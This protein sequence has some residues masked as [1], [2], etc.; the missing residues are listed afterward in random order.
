MEKKKKTYSISFE[1][2]AFDRHADAKRISTNVKNYSREIKNMNGH[3]DKLDRFDDF[4]SLKIPAEQFEKFDG[5]YGIARTDEHRGRDV[6]FA[7]QTRAALEFLRDKRGFGLL[8]DVVGSGKTY[9]AGLVVSELAARNKVRSILFI[10]PSQAI[11]DW[12][13]VM[14]MQFGFGKGSLYH[15]EDK[16]DKDGNVTQIGVPNR[17]NLMI[18][19]LDGYL[20]PRVPVIITYEQFVEWGSDC[21]D[22]LFDVIVV[23][24]AHHLCAE[25]G[26]YSRAMKSLSMLV[27]LK[28]KAKRS[29]CLLLSATPHS[30]NLKKMFR[31]WYFIRCTGGDPDDFDEKDDRDRTDYYRTEKQYYEDIVCKKAATVMDFVMIAK[32]E[33]VE[34]SLHW[35]AFEKYLRTAPPEEGKPPLFD[36]YANGTLAQQSEIISD[37]FLSNDDTGREIELNVARAYH[38]G[39][40][41]S[42]MIRHSNQ[43]RA[44]KKK[45]AVNLLFFRTEKSFNHQ[46]KIKDQGRDLTVD[47]DH[48]NDDH[49]IKYDDE[50]YSVA[51]YVRETRGSRTTQSAKADIFYSTFRL[52][53]NIDDVRSDNPFF[54]K[55]HSL[56]YYTNMMHYSPVEVENRLYVVDGNEEDPFEHKFA[57]F[58]EL[59]EKHAKQR[60]IVFFD[61][62]LKRKEAVIEKFVGRI[63]KSKY[64]NRFLNGCV[65]KKREIEKIFNEK[66]DALLVVTE[67]AF[68]ESVNLQTANI[69]V[70]FQVVVDPVSMDQRIGRVFRIGQKN[71]VIIYNLAD[72]DRLEGYA[73][74]YLSRIGLLTSNS[75][76]ATI[77]AGSNSDMMIA[78]R[79]DLCGKVKLIPESDY[80]KK[81]E[82][83]EMLC[84]TPDCRRQGKRFGKIVVTDFKCDQCPAS[85]SRSD[86]IEGY[87]CVSE[88]GFGNPK[89]ILQNRGAS[90]D[91]EYRC[92]KECAMLNC[93]KLQ[94]MNCPVVSVLRDDPKA[95]TSNLIMLCTKC[96]HKSDCAKR[97][98]PSSGIEGCMT[99]DY[100]I[101]STKPHKLVFN[102]KWEAVCPICG[103][104]NHGKLKPVIASSFASYVRC[105][106]DFKQD[107]GESFWGIMCRESEKV[108]Q[109]KRILDLAS[110]FD[111][112]EG[113]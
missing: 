87:E 30:G 69:V 86:E 56:Q 34:N 29:Y 102:E 100:A 112:Q 12:I 24:E 18:E 95:S 5:E 53:D 7:H 4:D 70:N 37:Y 1:A 25:E 26:E 99:C 14:E 11:S 33:E 113:N 44:S 22:L 17:K 13:R 106:W 57:A 50:F 79:C 43:D 63:K 16:K 49:A 6:L 20:V 94:E 85:L 19:Q 64:K 21:L 15:V 51:D 27:E 2:E 71:D 74:M 46:V 97:C 80:E 108:A 93:A 8:A 54:I 82:T 91:R 84:D 59:L 39:V 23:D 61:Y 36:Q 78:V 28:K 42:I 60:M 111:K 3:V 65:D 109:I 47:I 88:P 98:Q 96:P 104:T 76:D 103:K 92:R 75:G 38:R 32:K 101:C 58:T 10:V 72:M 107:K 35:D 83:D 105:S 31:L 73:L 68:T 81:K 66:E 45:N 48:Y 62:D 90:G 89:G 40:L 110:E 41:G 55:K 67:P 52:I 9:E 77:L